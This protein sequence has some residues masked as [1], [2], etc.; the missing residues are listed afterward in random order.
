MCMGKNIRYHHLRRPK[1]N[2]III[3]LPWNARQ[4]QNISTPISNQMLSIMPYLTSWTFQV[5]S[6]VYFWIQLED[7]TGI[8][9]TLRIQTWSPSFKTQTQPI[10]PIVTNWSQL[11]TIA[12]AIVALTR[13]SLRSSWSF[14]STRGGDRRVRSKFRS[15][16]L[17]RRATNF[18]SH[19]DRVDEAVPVCTIQPCTQLECKPNICS[20]CTSQPQNWWS[21]A[22]YLRDPTRQ[23]RKQ[24]EEPRIW[25]KSTFISHSWI[26]RLSKGRTL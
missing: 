20:E 9:L 6:Q 2:T 4:S 25:K 14:T 1:S 13:K 19:I 22:W 21:W 24:E 11:T 16:E 10:A 17:F 15:K 5:K 8:V 12:R 7:L 18:S 3:I 23:I 26:D